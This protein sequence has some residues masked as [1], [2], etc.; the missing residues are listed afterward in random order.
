MRFTIHKTLLLFVFSFT[1]NSLFCQTALVAGD[2]VIIG[3]KTSGGTEA[4]ND[5]I[6]LLTLVELSCNTKFTITD[7]NWRNTGM[8][9]CSNDEFAIE[10]TVSQRVAAGSVI[11]IDV[12]NSAGVISTSTGVLSKVSLGS[13]WGTNFGLNSGGDNLTI[14]QGDRSAPTFIYAIRHNGAFSGGGDCSSKDNT[15]IPTGLTL[16]STA[17]QMV[18]SQNQWHYNCMNSLTSGT[19]SALLTSLSNMA[20][21]TFAAGQ[22]WNSATCFFNVIDQFPIS[23]TL[24]VA[25]SGC[26]CLNGCNLTS[27]GG[28]NCNPA[29]AGDCISGQQNMSVNIPVPSGC[30]YTVYATMRPW[31]ACS[32]SGADG[33]ATGDQLKVD[34]QGGSKPNLT[35]TSNAMLND[36]YTLVGPGVITVS[37]RSNR[38]DEIIVYKFLSSQSACTICPILLPT[39]F[40]FFNVTKEGNAAKLDWSTQTEFNTSHFLIE[41]SQNGTDWEYYSVLPGAGNSSFPLSYRLYDVSPLKDL[42]YYRLTQ[43][44]INGEFE[45]LGIR[46]FS[47]KAERQLLKCVNLLGQEVSSNSNGHLIFYYD[48]GDVV[49]EYR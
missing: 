9:Y 25:G 7:N 21:W 20:N 19:K 4:G 6:K 8:W 35:G 30:S 24:A 18:S 42:S 13:D 14:L 5:A 17:L 15:S 49:R 26:G 43:F 37:G 28:V 44:D 32:S 27:V 48:T 39:E 23:G 34:I 41:R 1:I 29:V 40:A 10:V 36:S 11:Y 47:N 3:F 45:I 33:G 2:I 38:A 12:D 46:S 31:S 22:S 16:G